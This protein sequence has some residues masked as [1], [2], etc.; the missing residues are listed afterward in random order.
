MPASTVVRF[1]VL[2]AGLSAAAATTPPELP[3]A[4]FMEYPDLHG[5]RIVFSYENDLWAVSAS[6]GTAVRLTSW[7]GKETSPRFSPDGQWIAFTGSYDGA[8]AVY[9]MPAQG[10]APTRLTYN[11][12]GGM[13][14][15]WTPDGARVYFR[16][17]FEQFISR[18][19]NLYFVSR[20]GG[21]IER[22]PLDRGT[23]ASF[24]PDGQTL[25]YCRKGREEYQWK[26]YRGGH[27]VDIWSYDF[28][29]GRFEPL[30]DV[31]GKN[32]YPMWI[33]G[34][35]VYVSDQSGVCN[36]WAMPLPKGPGRQLTT[37]TDSDVMMAESDGTRV[38]YVQ[39]GTIHLFD[40]ATKADR[41]VAVTAPSDRWL[42]RDRVINP[43]EY[44]RSA[45]VFGDGARLVFEARGDVFVVPAD[46]RGQTRNLSNSPGT[47]GTLRG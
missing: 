47:R 42:S 25:L 5:D 7:P 28:T 32:A 36:L 35:M 13:A 15:G 3:E 39:D 26:R 38:V 12:G 18:D 17:A 46:A 37:Y 30:T 34:E 19:P 22:F 29:N 45:D 1:L 33:A 10:G 8:N 6:G 27:Y 41:K 23:L 43:R 40:P 11:P 4:R 9:L 20:E 21:P 44:I 16:S 31:V 14:L 2:A 24:S